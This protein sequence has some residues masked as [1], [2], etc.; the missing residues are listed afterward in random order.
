MDEI[1]TVLLAEDDANDVFMM[2][3]AVRKINAPI[4]LQV[5]KDGEEAIDYLSGQH[6][7]SDRALYPLPR[8]ILLDINMPRKNGFD[9]LRWLKEDGTLAHIPAVMITSSKVRSDRDTACELGARAYLVKPV[10]HDE[11]QRLL[12]DDLKSRTGT[13]PGSNFN[14]QQIS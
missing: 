6:K 8:L 14:N 9:V 11:L 7:Y 10:R 3:R 13:G 1:A 2:Q 4:T 12:N 5:A